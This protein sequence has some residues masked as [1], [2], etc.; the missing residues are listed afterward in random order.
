MGRDSSTLQAEMCKSF[1]EKKKE[2]KK[3]LQEN[4]YRGKMKKGGRALRI[5]QLEVQFLLLS[6]TEEELE[7]AYDFL[8]VSQLASWSGTSPLSP[9]ETRDE[10]LQDSGNEVQGSALQRSL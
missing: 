6:L 1:R 9:I 4:V 5:V 8:A 2:K 7:L 3:K 10:C